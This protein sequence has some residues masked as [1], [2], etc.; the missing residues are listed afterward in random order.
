[1]C[2]KMHNQKI[3]ISLDYKVEFSIKMLRHYNVGLYKNSHSG[4]K[5]LNVY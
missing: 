2:N 1:M 3:E 4:V 5:N